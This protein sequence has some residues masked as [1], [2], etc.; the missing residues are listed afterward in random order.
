MSKWLGS[1][2]FQGLRTGWSVASFPDLSCLCT[3]MSWSYLES[4]LTCFLIKKM[5]GKMKCKHLCFKISF[6]NAYKHPWKYQIFSF[7]FNVYPNTTKSG[8]GTSM[9]TW[10][11]ENRADQSLRWVQIFWLSQPSSLHM[12]EEGRSPSWELYLLHN[13]LAKESRVWLSSSSPG[14]TR[15]GQISNIFFFLNWPIFKTFDSL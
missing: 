6:T 12:G 13:P 1:C 8:K 15:R 14:K 10:Q 3:T 7:L 2:F 4:L 5:R 11:L 9:V